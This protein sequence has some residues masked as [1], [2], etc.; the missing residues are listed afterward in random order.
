MIQLFEKKDRTDL[1]PASHTDKTF[2]FLDRSAKEEVSEMRKLLNSWFNRYPK[3]DKK[4]LKSR[5]A[6]EFSPAFYELF[7]HELFSQQGF[8]LSVHP[9][10]PGT[11][12]QPDFLASKDGFEFYIEAKEATDKTDSERSNDNKMGGVYNEL[13][14]IKSPNFLLQIDELLLKSNNQPSLKNARGSIEGKLKSF[15]PDEVTKDLN[16]KGFDNLPTIKYENNDMKIVV[17]IIPK[18][19]E[20]RGNP[21]IRPIGVYPGNFSWGGAD[22]SIKSAIEK[23]ANRYGKLNKPFLVCINSTSHRG[24]AEMDIRNA[25][26]GTLAVTWSTNPANRDERLERGRDGIFYNTHGPQFTR[27]SGVLFTNVRIDNLHIAKHWLIAHPFAVNKLDYSKFE[28]TYV[29]GDRKATIVNK[30]SIQEL[31]SIPDNWAN[32]Q[33]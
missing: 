28:I 9:K 24:I 27:M 26:W 30:K 1:S 12:K 5:F 19:P 13:N 22:E 20:I 4:D 17:T 16:E 23:K 21:E 10:V 8:Q 6:G 3:E 15:D 32:S 29:E 18:P 2:D 33:Q 7:I 31:L 25:L 11:R 14:K